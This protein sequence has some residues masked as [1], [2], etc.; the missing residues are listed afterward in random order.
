MLWEIFRFLLQQVPLAKF[1]SRL[2]HL[3]GSAAFEVGFGFALHFD[4][5][6]F[7]NRFE[8]GPMFYNHMGTLTLTNNIFTK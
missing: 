7:Y 5:F 8:E 1:A 4:S 3:P 2:A 6:V